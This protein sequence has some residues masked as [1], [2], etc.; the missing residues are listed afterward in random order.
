[1]EVVAKLKGIAMGTHK[2]RHVA[3]LV[4]NKSAAEAL[5]ILQGCD[6]RAAGPLEK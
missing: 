3:A 1:M 6:R 5:S 4:R 2:G